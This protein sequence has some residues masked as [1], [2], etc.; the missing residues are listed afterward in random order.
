[1]RVIVLGSGSSGNSILVESGDTRLLVDAGFSGRDLERRLASVA[2]EAARSPVSSSRTTTAI[3]P[4]E[5]G[6]RPSL[7]RSALPHRAYPSCLLA[8]PERHR[9][10]PAY[11]SAEPFLIGDLLVEPFLTVHDAVDPVA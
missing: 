5:W 2:V 9:R 8:A 1:V 10:C 11:S 3:T 4:A 7:G 6:R